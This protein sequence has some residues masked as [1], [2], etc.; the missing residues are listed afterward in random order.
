MESSVKRALSNHEIQDPRSTPETKVHSTLKESS[1]KRAL[2]TQESC[3]LPS[4]PVF[5]GMYAKSLSHLEADPVSLEDHDPR[6]DDESLLFLYGTVNGHQLSFM[7]DSGASSNFISQEVVKNLGIKTT[8]KKHP[9]VVSIAD[10]R[11]LSCT[12]YALV[13]V[14]IHQDYCPVLMFNV[15]DMKFEAILGKGWLASSQ[16][17]PDVDWLNNTVRIN[18]VLIQ[19]HTRPCHVPVLSA[20]QF[21]RCLQKDQAFLCFVHKQDDSKDHKPQ[22]EIHP[23]A[24]ELLEKYK[25]VFPDELPRCLPPS[26]SIDHKIELVPGSV[27]PS[28]P[29]YQLS[30]SEMD[31][32]KKQLQDLFDHGFI[33]PSQSPYGSPVL[34]V[35]KKEGDLRMCVDYR[36]LN[37]QTIKNTYPLP[38]I[39][40][41]MD[42]LQGATVFSKLDLRSGYHQIRISEEDIHKTAFRT[43]YGLYEFQVLPFGLTNAPATFMTLMN[44]VFREELDCCVIIYLDDLLIF[45]KDPHQHA[46]DLEK[47]LAKLKAEKLYA[48]LSKCEFFKSEVAFLGHVVSAE[49]IKVDPSKVKCIVEWPALT[50]VLD[51]QS[52]L[53]LV[54][55]YRRFIQNLAKIAAPL[56]E[57]LKKKNPFIWS[58][59]QVKAFQALKDA[60]VHAPVLAIFNPAKDVS[61]HADA[62]NFAVAAVLMQDGH[63]IA[64][65]SRKLSSAEMNYPIHEKEQL[66]I[67]YA[68]TKWRVYLHSTPKPFIV[69]T[70]HESLKYLDT[71][72]SLSPRQI[73]WSEKLAEYNFEIKYKKGTLNVVPDALS[74]RPDYQLSLLSEHR[75]TVSS[76]TLLQVQETLPT[77][78]YFGPIYEKASTVE[79]DDPV[80]EFVVSNKTLYLKKDARICIPDLPAIKSMLLKEMHDSPLSGHNGVDK[81][82]SRLATLCYWPRMRKSVQHYVDSC[83]TCKTMKSRTVK[84]NGLLQP[85]PIPEHP[86]SHIAMDLITHLPKTKNNH[87]AVAVFVDRFSK[88]AQFI[89][90]KTTCS[91]S[92]LAEIF[93]K[94]IFKNF[95]LPKS[96]VSDRDP[97]FTSL[98]W[99]SLFSSLGTSLDMST[100]HHQQTDGQ[101]ER[102]IQT[103]E[104]YLRTYASD[105][106]DDW[107]LHLC[108][109]EF[110]YNSAQSSPTGFSPFE[111]LYGFKPQDPASLLLALPVKL[112]VP[113]AQEFAQF[114]QARFKMVQDALQDAHQTMATQYDKHHQPVSFEIGSLVYLDGEHIKRPNHN[115]STK[116]IPH[117]LGP[118]KILAKPSPLNYKLDLPPGSKIHPVFHV[119]KLRHHTTRN[120]DEFPDSEMVEVD[121]SPLE[122]E[123]GLYYQE[124]YEVEKILQHKTMPDGTLKFRVKWV[125]YPHSQNTWQ[126]LDDLSNCPEALA[127]YK[128]T[129]KNPDLF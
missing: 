109:A 125:D 18:D 84:E 83:H 62:S 81:T 119:S 30:L 31:E 98:F 69:F 112:P 53:G 115:S 34:F 127:K 17:R 101:S 38:R 21:K 45:S 80:S 90:C 36:A 50:C 6:K 5:S 44:D 82:Y 43:R 23:L 58:T 9:S 66:A 16:P 22:V 114:H 124:E 32:L 86:W 48:K 110:A 67:V 103:L 91:A 26:R 59:L 15:I 39:D 19:G 121:P 24:Q 77:D 47:I 126:T 33:R 94:H 56:T 102:T 107:D 129:L 79:E 2:S 20:M 72:T 12:Q 117:F 108:H 46:I 29:T 111:A 106:Q 51:I 49:G 61:V 99:T 14:K 40:E 87:D 27:P 73:R 55:Y 122:L 89:P 85:L 65:E 63:P 128:S 4:V 100:A 97:R 96:I 68:L 78:K 76:E 88:V 10:D 92:D 52:F 35:K 71:K 13:K 57:L 25:D 118:Y 37:K 64:F 116:F 95:G 1:V 74:R 3:P 113:G 8:K 7:V 105:A 28:R 93:F 123:D 104:Q 70:D 75:P 11:P 41:L 120:P 60:L 54:N 42:R